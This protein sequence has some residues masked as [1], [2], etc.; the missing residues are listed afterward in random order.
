[1]GFVIFLKIKLLNHNSKA[2]CFIRSYFCQIQATSVTTVGFSQM[3]RRATNN[4]SVVYIMK[5]SAGCVLSTP[6]TDLNYFFLCLFFLC[7][8]FFHIS[9]E[10]LFAR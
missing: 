2:V 10:Q 7:V 5:Y 4:L 9:V 8:F 6:C 1:M 3:N